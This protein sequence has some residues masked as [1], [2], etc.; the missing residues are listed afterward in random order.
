MPRDLNTVGGDEEDDDLGEPA[1][2]EIDS[3]HQ[4]NT[5]IDNLCDI[6]SS[7]DKGRT[8]S[9]YK[10]DV[11]DNEQPLTPLNDILVP[12][13]ISGTIYRLAIYDEAFYRRLR[14]VVPPEFCARYVL[15]GADPSYLV[16]TL[17]LKACFRSKDIFLLLRPVLQ[18]HCL[19]RTNNADP[20]ICADSITISS[21]REHS[22]RFN[23]LVN[24]LRE[25]LKLDTQET[26]VTALSKLFFFPFNPLFEFGDKQVRASVT[27]FASRTSLQAEKSVLRR[28]M[29]NPQ[30]YSTRAME[31]HGCP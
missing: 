26:M 12:E 10:R 9:E 2:E 1:V 23:C 5:R 29:L 13:N 16:L 24:M 17:S 7:F 21:V 28:K 25:D 31:R 18:L 8:P 15:F 22:L 27:C 11:V 20:E 3:S 30:Y 4:L 6:L 14:Q 19:P